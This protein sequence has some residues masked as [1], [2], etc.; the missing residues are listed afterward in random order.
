MYGIK[1]ILGVYQGFVNS[2]V[3]AY[4]RMFVFGY[5]IPA[6]DFWIQPIRSRYVFTSL[7]EFYTRDK[8][9][10]ILRISNS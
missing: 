8:G 2:F 9:L 4:I 10:F 6:L 1:N 5:E 7:H 3:F